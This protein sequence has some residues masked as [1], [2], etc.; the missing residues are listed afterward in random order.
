MEK[1]KICKHDQD[2]ECFWEE[3]GNENVAKLSVT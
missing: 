3:E 2:Q 1:L